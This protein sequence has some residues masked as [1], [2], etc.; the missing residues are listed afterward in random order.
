MKNV[1][2]AAAALATVSLF[3]ATGATAG[4]AALVEDVPYTWG[5]DEAANMTDVFGAG[6]FSETDYAGANASSLF[7]SANSFVMLEGGDSSTSELNDFLSA[8]GSTITSWVNGGGRL[9]LQSASNEGLSVS[10]VGP[11]TL[12]PPGPFSP[13]GTL[14]AAGIAA[15]TFAPTPV[16]QSGSYLA[17]DNITGS[18]LTTFMT[19]SS[20]AYPIIAGA[21][22]GSGYVMYS[23]LTTSNF[24]FAGNGLTDD[25]I[26]V[27]ANGGAGAVPE[28]VT[29]ALMLVG[30]GAVGGAMRAG[31]KTSALQT[32]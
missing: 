17:H 6:N 4:G 20:G 15:F 10:G 3:G 13:D 25:V 22:V 21:Q 18:G 8:N 11:G 23:A 1:M 2:I 28:P 32:A 31:R 14:T 27:T 26:A 19:D 12:N 5:F 9:L 29:W 30:I 7:S 24:H 16:N